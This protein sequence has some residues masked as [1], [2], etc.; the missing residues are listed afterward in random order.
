VVADNRTLSVSSPL[1]TNRFMIT[2]LGETLVT[3]DEPP[4]SL[5]PS[6]VA[7]RAPPPLPPAGE[8]SPPAPDEMNPWGTLSSAQQRLPSAPS[9][10]FLEPP[11]RPVSLRLF[12][13]FLCRVGILPR[14]LVD[15]PLRT[16]PFCGL[17][18]LH[19]SSSIPPLCRRE[20]IFSTV[21]DALRKTM[22]F[23]S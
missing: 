21:S 22:L 2:T 13:L 18:C 23:P 14:V 15:A 7:F 8:S 1:W 16:F 10:A 12:L 9:P 19:V 4:S 17:L 6:F 5:F 3:M 20:V 11:Q